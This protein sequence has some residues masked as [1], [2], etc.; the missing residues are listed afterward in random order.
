MCIPIFS[1]KTNY[2]KETYNRKMCTTLKEI[3]NPT[4]NR[5]TM[6]SKDVYN[7]QVQKSTDCE[8]K[9]FILYNA[10]H[11]PTARIMN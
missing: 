4:T 3:Q 8:T 10:H 9:L 6:K 11:T 5:P 2:Y 7:Q 1:I